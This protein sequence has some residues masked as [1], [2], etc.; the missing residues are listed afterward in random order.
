MSLLSDPRLV[1]DLSKL[2][3][4]LED[5]FGCYQSPKNLLSCFNSGQWYQDE[6]QLCCIDPSKDF[7]VPICFACDEP[8]L[9]SSGHTGCCPLVFS[10][11]IFN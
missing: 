10:T 1:G 6:N 7:L 3:V 8:K 4:N 5:P 9:S 2:D 11:T